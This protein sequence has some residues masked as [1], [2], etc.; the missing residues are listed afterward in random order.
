M[1]FLAGP[2]MVE[3]PWGDLTEDR[4]GSIRCASGVNRP[5]RQEPT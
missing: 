1:A 3:I 4:K 2:A 5:K